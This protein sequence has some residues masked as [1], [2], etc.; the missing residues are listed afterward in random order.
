MEID[1]G[2]RKDLMKDLTWLE[3]QMLELNRYFLVIIKVVGRVL[4]NALGGLWAT[5]YSRFA[6]RILRCLPAVT[7]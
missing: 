1:P 6:E 5:V 4:R 7:C 2:P 3:G